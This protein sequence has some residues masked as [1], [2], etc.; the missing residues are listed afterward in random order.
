MKLRFESRPPF[1]YY[2]NPDIQLEEYFGINTDGNGAY[3]I[4]F[5]SKETCVSLLKIQL[6]ILRSIF[7]QHLS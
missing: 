5:H 4:G 3:E 2:F 1:V 6:P 7:Y